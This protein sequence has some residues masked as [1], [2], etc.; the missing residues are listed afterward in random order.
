MG[1]QRAL[2]ARRFDSMSASDAD[3]RGPPL[4]SLSPQAIKAASRPKLFP[5]C[6]IFPSR[7]KPPLP[8]HHRLAAASLRRSSI[9]FAQLTAMSW[10]FFCPKLHHHWPSP[11]P[12]PSDHATACCA[13]RE[14]APATRWSTLA[15]W[16][17][18][19]P[20]DWADL[21]SPLA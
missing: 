2:M 17:A 16:A 4:S 15:S 14:R 19:R 3:P 12:S 18:H 10:R 11:L 9:L 21:V 7:G 5:F 13:R 20:A 1:N 6:R 8:T